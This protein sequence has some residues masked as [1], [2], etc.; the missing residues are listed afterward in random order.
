ME[1][2]V[3]QAACLRRI[4]VALFAAGAVFAAG[5]LSAA[6]GKWLKV[7]TPHFTVLTAAS[8]AI[9][10][11]RAIELEQF[12]GALQA[13]LP[14]PVERLR[15][16]TVVLFKNRRTL[17]PFLPLENGRPAKIDGYFARTDD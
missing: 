15:P 2:P 6:G 13:A 14:V 10:R 7:S 17:E 9:A 3:K 4:R 8:E 5:R 1:F 16:V 12:R 11:A